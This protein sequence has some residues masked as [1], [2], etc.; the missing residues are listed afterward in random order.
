M[1]KKVVLFLLCA[2][3]SLIIGLIIYFKFFKISNSYNLV[4]GVIPSYEFLSTDGVLVS[5]DTLSADNIIIVFFSKDC[6]LCE[7]QGKDLARNSTLFGGSKILF[8]TIE[9]FQSA[10]EYSNTHRLDAIPNYYC[11]YDI[12]T[13][14]PNVFGVNSMPTTIL[15]DS[16]REL[17]ESFRGE[18]NANKIYATIQGNE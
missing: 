3:I 15:Y 9:S 17:I 6:M 12:T 14:S 13:M 7:H 18:V 8:V 1:N 2:I 5:I 4:P 16:E 10:I 11:L